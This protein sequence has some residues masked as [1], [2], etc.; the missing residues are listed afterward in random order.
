MAVTINGS[1]A[2]AYWTFKLVVSEGA[3]NIANNTSPLTVDV[4]IGRGASAGSSYMWGAN[5]SC[6]VSVT[7]CNTQTITYKN[8]NKVTVAAG[9]WLHIGSITFEAVP[10]NSDGSKTVTVSATFTNNISPSSGSAS[11]SVNLT[12]IPRKSTLSVSNGTLGTAQTLTVARQSTAFTHTVKYSCGGYSG[13]ICAKSTAESLSFT[14]LLEFANGAPNGKTV[15]VSFTIETFNGNT[16]LDTNSYGAQYNIPN[17]VIPSVEIATSDPTGY[18][19]KYGAF[20]Q[21]HSKF[22]V[23]VSASGVYGSTIKSYKIE[24][25]GKTYTSIPVTT[26]VISGKDELTIKAT[27]TD[28]RERASAV[29]GKVDVL[30]YKAPKI[31]SISVYRCNEDGVK[32]N[33][34]GYL[35]VKFSAEIT[36]LNNVNS[37]LYSVRYKKT[38]DTD[39][40]TEVITDYSGQY[41]IENG[42]FVFAADTSSSYDIILTASD[43]F[44][45]VERTATG[46][47]IKKLWS[48]LKKGFGFAFGKIA[49]LENTIEFALDAVFHNKANFLAEL[50][51]NGIDLDYIV[52]QGLSDGGWFYRKWNSGIA[53]C[54]KIHTKRS[55]NVAEVNYSGFYYSDTLSVAYPF[56]FTN[57]PT[58]IITGGS[59]DHM[60][61]A[62]IF[63]SYKDKAAFVVVGLSA[64]ATQTDINVNI[65]AVGRWK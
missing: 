2:S 48:I 60:N 36:A 59:N 30:P 52:E 29:S 24:A 5:I 50:Q 45:G 51:I 26:D 37:A 42:V 44:S 40:T 10:H 61:L 49:E 1:T 21:G 19:N 46:S 18:K 17:N 39:Y 27:V 3:V 14:P 20:I 23:D 55:V 47:S 63:G 53:E 8:S 7:G 57:Y 25:D 15:Y 22:K 32:V 34:G 65:Y 12:T 33:S 28:S 11:G 54:W 38:T 9:G 35:A 31:S 16:S 13:T 6:P 64:T 58:V 4:Y 56:T 41:I 62:R 43:D